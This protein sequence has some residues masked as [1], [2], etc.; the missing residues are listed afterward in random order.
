MSEVLMGLQTL[1]C[2]LLFL[3]HKG[4]CR[5][6]GRVS[7][8]IQFLAP[9]KSNR[10]IHNIILHPTFSPNRVSIHMDTARLR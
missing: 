6:L 10:I 1:K 5:I 3:P 2:Y 4:K 7:F 8:Q 9:D